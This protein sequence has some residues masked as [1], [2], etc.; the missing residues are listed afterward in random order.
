MG[1]V[2]TV[3]IQCALLVACVALLAIVAPEPARL[4]V[5]LCGVVALAFFVS[6]SCVRHAQITRLARRIDEV[7]HEGRQID[8]SNCS[9][10]DIAVLSNELS[11][12]VSRLA[13]TNLLL[14][15]ERNALSDALADVSHQIR[16]P[17]TAATLMLPKVERADDARERKQAVRELESM[18]ERIS[19]LVTSLL[20]I[21]KVDAGA[22]RV[23]RAQ[24]DVRQMAA[25]A[26]DPLMAAMDLHDVELVL[27]VEEGASFSGDMLW[28]T[29]AVEN[30]LKDCMEHTPCG[31]AVTLRASEDALATRIV[32]TDTGPGFA[33]D[34]LPRIFDRFYRGDASTQGFGIGLALAQAL[35][36]V[37][38]G[39]L[40][41]SNGP[42][43]GARFVIAFP[44]LVV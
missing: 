40:S 36:S 6:V 4:W 29:E 43:G 7:L 35:V 20:K 42:D 39:T 41:A 24:V 1:S 18:I 37:Q 9:E 26:T 11:K 2:R 16:T 28:T 44:K 3:A 5:V 25:R 14:E 32:I 12:M 8:F 33:P 27:E 31:G 13:R 38:G 22:I 10:G 19:W 17:L 15:S 30:I 21:A 23:E 34:D